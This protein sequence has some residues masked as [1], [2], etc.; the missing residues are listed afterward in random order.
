MLIRKI[1]IKK[2]IIINFKL[3]KY[4]Q[5]FFWPGIYFEIF[6]KFC[7]IKLKPVKSILMEK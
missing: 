3:F 2:F 6:F 4:N 5:N 7:K 1:I